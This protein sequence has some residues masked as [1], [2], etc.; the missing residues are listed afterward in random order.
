ISLVF[1]FF[2]VF[3]YDLLIIGAA[4]LLPERTANLMIF[5]SLFGNPVDLARVSSLLA[6]GDATIFGAAG[7][8]L[9][10]FLGGAARAQAVLIA[11][12]LLWL[13][14]ALSAALRTVRRLDF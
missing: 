8:A 10:K 6:V 9:L 13:V 5:L 4:F 11:M 7:A 1:W 14:T 12:L 2:F 3:L